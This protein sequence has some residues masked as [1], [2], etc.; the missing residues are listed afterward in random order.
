MVGRGPTDAR[1]SERS[2]DCWSATKARAS[3][4]ESGTLQL[5]QERDREPERGSV[6]VRGMLLQPGMVLPG[7]YEILE[8]IGSGGMGEVL[9]AR[10]LDEGRKVA[11]KVLHGRSD[12][13]PERFDREARAA[14]RI[15]HPN[16]VEFLDAGQTASGLAFYVMEYLDGETLAATLSREGAMPPWRACTLTIQILSAL[17]AAHQRGVVHRDLKPGNCLRLGTPGDELVKLLD[18]GI[19]KVGSDS[20]ADAQGKGLTGTGEVF[21][22]AAYMSPEQ[23]RGETL[24]ARSDMYSLGIMAYQMLV[25]QVPFTGMNAIHVI[26]QH[27]VGKP[28]P[29]RSHDGSIPPVVEAL[30]LKMM[31][32]ERGD[33]FASMAE[34]EQAL[35]ELPEEVQRKTRLWSSPGELRGMIAEKR[36]AGAGA[37][38]LPPAID[39]GVTSPA[40][41]GVK[42]SVAR[43]VDPERTEKVAR[44]KEVAGVGGGKRTVVSAERPAVGASTTPVRAAGIG[45]A[46]S[47][48]PFV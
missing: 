46:S 7:G 10:T 31:A 8:R 29:L 24:D 9:L 19:A 20:H 16:V 39:S 32:K 6:S 48:S 40:G 28:E 36:G 1:R 38:V 21:G 18:F 15:R 27:M 5:V 26:T 35:R 22:T 3:G 34:V 44:K 17:E 41:V 13:E 2:V 14:A 47:A 33:R 30:V 25:G 12:A 37:G 45:A 43:G 4:T 11:V 42:K 23:A